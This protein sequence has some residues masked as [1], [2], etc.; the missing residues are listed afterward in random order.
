MDKLPIDLLSSRE[1][2]GYITLTTKSSN[3]IAVA[4]SDFRK[5]EP[6]T[7]GKGSVITYR[8]GDREFVQEHVDEIFDKIVEASINTSTFINSL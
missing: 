5:I 3:R 6:S 8:N 4:S 1:K 7:E 2:L